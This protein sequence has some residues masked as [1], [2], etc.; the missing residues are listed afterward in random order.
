MVEKCVTRGALLYRFRAATDGGEES[1]F[2]GGDAGRDGVGLVATR[3]SRGG[4]NGG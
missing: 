1:R 2:R 4:E 3:R